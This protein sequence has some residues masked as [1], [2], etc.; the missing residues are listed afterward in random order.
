MKAG[1]SAPRSCAAEEVLVA[2]VLRAGAGS[3][4]AFAAHAPCR[5]DGRFQYLSTGA[6]EIWVRFGQVVAGPWVSFL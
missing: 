5:A 4:L 6:E 2:R 1:P 3:D